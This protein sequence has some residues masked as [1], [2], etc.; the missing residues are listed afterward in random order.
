MSI[1]VH[2]H[3]YFEKKPAGLILDGIPVITVRILN[4]LQRANIPGG[5]NIPVSGKVYGP[6]GL[7]PIWVDV[8]GDG[9]DGTKY[10]SSGPVNIAGDGTWNVTIG[11]I[12]AAAGKLSIYARATTFD[13][14]I[15]SGGDNDK[16]ARDDIVINVT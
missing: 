13:P 5:G 16:S 11:G 1:E 12:P 3:Y 7:P 14:T 8:W 15:G 2:H 9:S 10:L 4:P 6:V